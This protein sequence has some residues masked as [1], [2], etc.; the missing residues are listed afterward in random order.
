[1]NVELFYF[2]LLLVHKTF[3]KYVFPS[4]VVLH[5]GLY[6]THARG[7]EVRDYTC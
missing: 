3:G 4:S 6:L 5:K 7:S 2:F 1:M